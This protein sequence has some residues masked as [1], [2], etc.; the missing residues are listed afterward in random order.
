[1]RRILRAFTLI[2]LL[3]VIAIIAILAALLLPALAAAREKARR[4]A[5]IN[6]LKEIGVALASYT[7]DY[8]EYLPSHPGWRPRESDFCYPNMDDCDYEDS[9][10]SKLHETGTPSEAKFVHR[11]I[12]ATF[13]ART[14]D[15][16][17]Q[18]LHLVHPSW[19]ATSD[20]ASAYR[21]I[22]FGLKD[23]GGYFREGDLNN[24]PVGL[25]FLLT[26]GY[27]GDAKVYYCPSSDGMISPWSG[28]GVSIGAARVG[29]WKNA[30]GTDKDAF[31]FGDWMPT[32]LGTYGH[33]IFSHY[34]YR[35]Q[36]LATGG[37]MW[38]RYDE[39]TQ[40][41]IYVLG[42]KPELTARAS[43][44][45]FRTVK[46]LAARAIVSDAFGK[47]E[48]VDVHGNPIGIYDKKAIEV[49]QLIPGMGMMAHRD[50]YNILY[51]D[52]HAKYFGDPQQKVVWHT[53]GMNG[54]TRTK[55]RQDTLSYNYYYGWWGPFSDDAT[56]G[57]LD[58]PFFKD[59]ALAIWHEFDVSGGI[60]VP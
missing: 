42:V 56:K 20:I 39:D 51:G 6:N 14:P 24:A 54:E 60:D 49:S 46:E 45:L 27:M 5:C 7:G 1:M 4:T 34:A 10:A 36:L 12:G 3:V 53:Q 16:T 44:P 9:G 59:T 22:G 11:Y 41:R 23:A 8:G 55:A 58:S 50:G 43:Q 40:G 37:S 2:E 47:G 33:A 26:G 29:D 19:R 21:T 32:R 17:T 57:D 28:S 13:K 31:L 25:G 30:G 38:H 15:G 18:E 52:G 48:S 35:N